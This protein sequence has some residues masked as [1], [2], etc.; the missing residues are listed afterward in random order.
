M[1]PTVAF[2]CLALALGADTAAAEESIFDPS[3]VQGSMS[4]GAAASNGVSSWT[5][6]GFGKSQFG[7]GVNGSV[8]AELVWHPQMTNSLS[9]VVDTISQANFARSLDVAE[10]YLLYKPI[11]TSQT[12]IK[13]RA[14]L[15]YIPVS[16]EHNDAE[17]EPW[18]VKDTI[19]PSAINT[20]IGEE[21]KALGFEGTVEHVFE[22]V[23]T[24]LTLGAFSHNDTSG[25]LLA[26]RGWAFSD[27]V[28]TAS[29]RAPLPPLSDYDSP[30][31]ADSQQVAKLDNRLGGYAKLK[32]SSQ[33]GA[34]DFMAYDN[35]AT[36][37]SGRNGQW[38][39][40]TRFYNMGAVVPLNPNLTL[41]GQVLKGR[42]SALLG[43]LEGYRFDVTF[44]SAYLKLTE[45]FGTDTFTERL[46][47]FST[48]NQPLI[49]GDL[50]YHSGPPDFDE[51]YF[52]NGWAGLGAWKHQLNTNRSILVEVLQIHWKRP[53]MAAFE[54]APVQNSTTLQVA[55]RLGF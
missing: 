21:T 3:T 35:H 22:P 5:H 11:P 25:T 19:T 40:R 38:G 20:W 7:R 51:T 42:T 55:Y 27:L 54:L 34:L 33:L 43:G 52:E 28:A 53:Y 10:A 12:R 2:L 13:A 32:F 18:L 49:P 37:G 50:Y 23:K 6:G 26:L 16:L 9:F 1:R 46:E 29:S 36:P 41:S 14:G 30:Q 48:N 8:S 24:S 44:N 15:L 45:H 39:W 17:G 4:L 31:A 47:S